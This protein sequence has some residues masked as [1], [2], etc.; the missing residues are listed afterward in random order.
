MSGRP[1]MWGFCQFVIK[2]ELLDYS[3]DIRASDS[4]PCPS[5][6]RNVFPKKL[7]P[8]SRFEVIDGDGISKILLSIP[9][10]GPLIS[11]L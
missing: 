4:I 7:S 3:Y 8:L 6:A 11:D 9:N 5:G 2:E 1:S 10:F